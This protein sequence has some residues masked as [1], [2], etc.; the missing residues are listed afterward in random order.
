MLTIILET[1]VMLGQALGVAALIYGIYLVFQASSY[2]SNDAVENL[3]SH[4]QE[5]NS[6]A[7]NVS[8]LAHGNHSKE[9]VSYRRVA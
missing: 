8:T 4:R 1:L 7:A 5:K 3:Q 9:S 2:S 6:N